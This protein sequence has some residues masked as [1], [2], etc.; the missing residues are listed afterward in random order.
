VRSLGGIQ[1]A[2]GPFG[3]SMVLAT[4]DVERTFIGTARG[5][6]QIVTGS[7]GGDCGYHFDRGRKYLVYAWKAPSGRYATSICSR[8]RPVEDA[9]EDLRYLTTIADSPGAR[10]YGRVTHVQRDPF[11]A[12]AVDRGPLPGVMVRLR[13]TRF[14]RDVVTDASG[15]YE[16]TGVDRGAMT[17]T[18][19]TPPGFDPGG[20]DRQVKITDRRACSEQ[21]FPLTQ[22]A[23]AS[24]TIVDASG[25]PMAG[26]RVDAVAE[27]LAA[28][29]PSPYQR[30]VETDAQGAFR[31]EDLPPGRYVFG[32]NL[33][34]RWTNEPDSPSIFF[35]GTSDPKQAAVFELKPGD[36]TDVGIL[37]LPPR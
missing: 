37:R 12:D 36:R 21:D 3:Y 27:E 14:A 7:G 26:V 33:T 17:I 30:P 29:R 2:G 20:N 6:V 24:G 4:L 5:R 23:E 18:V 13:T 28:H 1:Q 32:V 9:D 34:R 16:F 35:P 25:R 31:F 10:V 15:H 19:M 8:T 22:V 11:E